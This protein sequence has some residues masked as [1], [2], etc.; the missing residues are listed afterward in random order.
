MKMF[1]V[2]LGFLFSNLY[3]F[4]NV[5]IFCQSF[6]SIDI[7]SPYRSGLKPLYRKKH[8]SIHDDDNNN[9]VYDFQKRIPIQDNIHKYI[10]KT[11]N[12]EKYMKYLNDPS[13]NIVIGIGPAGSGKTLLACYTAIQLYKKGDI[14]HIIITRPLV[15]V[16]EESIGYLP[17]NLVSKMQ[18]WTQPIMDIFLEFF[19]VGEINNLIMKGIIEISPLAF[20]RGR[21]FKN[22]F[23]IADEMQNSSPNQMLMMNTRIGTN[24]KLVI[25]GDLKQTDRKDINGLSDFIHKFGVFSNFHD[26][27][28]TSVFMNCSLHDIQ[29]IELTKID[30]IRNP[31][32]SK[33]IDIYN[34]NN[35]N[36]IINDTLIL[37]EPVVNNNNNNNTLM[38]QEP[39]VNNDINTSAYTNFSQNSNEIW[40]TKISGFLQKRNRTQRN[41]RSNDA[42]LIP[43]DDDYY[44]YLL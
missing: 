36:D 27:N 31:I 7:I 41:V 6:H 4:S 35:T 21:T 2:S 14:Q 26:Q 16:D 37:Q 3:S 42:A 30:I 34:F 8:S 24:S 25:T 13:V 23:I 32:V 11:D 10:P 28:T 12:Q 18:P 1:F 39:V 22:S 29:I 9:N 17:G 33:I 44:Y 19:S 38:L 43:R 40:K 15:A 20:M 5:N